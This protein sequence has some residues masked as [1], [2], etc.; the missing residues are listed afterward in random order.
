[1]SKRFLT[2]LALV[3]MLIAAMAGSAFAAPTKW[4][5]TTDN[6][7]NKAANWDSGLPSA[8]NDAVFDKSADVKVTATIEVEKIT[9]NASL[10][11]VTITPNNGVELKV[12]DAAGITANSNLTIAGAGLVL[13]AGV[14]PV[15]LTV[16]AGAV[17]NF[18]GP[19]NAA[20]S[21][22]QK[23]G[24]GA[25]V[26]SGNTAPTTPVAL[27]VAAGN[28]FLAKGGLVGAI[29]IDANG[30]DVALA[31]S[32]DATMSTAGDLT[33][34]DA[35]S[36]VITIAEGAK[37]TL[38]DSLVFADAL[39]GGATE[40][41]IDGTLEA[42]KGS[43]P[44]DFTE[45]VLEINGALDLK[46]A[47]VV[48][49][50][51]GDGAISTVFDLTFTEDVTV[52]A[53]ISGRGN[54][55]IDNNA[56]VEFVAT[57]TY[58]GQ[59]TVAGGTTLK[60]HGKENLGTGA[61]T[62][63]GTFL[64]LEGDAVLPNTVILMAGNK[65]EVSAD[66]TLAITNVL[67]SNETMDKEGEGK[68]IL[69]G[70]AVS[71]PSTGVRD[72]IKVT[73]GTVVISSDK[74]AGAGDLNV[75]TGNTL[76]IAPGLT[77]TNKIDI[78][79]N[80]N[81]GVQISDGQAAFKLDGSTI[82][83]AGDVNIV[84]VTEGSVTKDQQFLVIDAAT[85]GTIDYTA[86]T[87]LKPVDAAGSALPFTPSKTT[88]ASGEK[89]YFTA[90]KNMDFPVIGEADK[91]E[92]EVSSDVTINIAVESMSE[93]RSPDFKAANPA[94]SLDIKVSGKQL[95]LT[96]KAPAVSGDF[97]F[98]VM[99]IASGDAETDGFASERKEFTM[100][101]TEESVTPPVSED[102][103]IDGTPVA[104]KENGTYSISA[105]LYRNGMLAANEAVTG[106]LDG[107]AAARRGANYTSDQ[108]TDAAGK[109]T[110]S[111]TGIE[112]DTYSFYVTD[113]SGA[114]LFGPMPVT[115][116]EAGVVPPVSSD[117]W[118]SGSSGCDAGFGLFALLAGVGAAVVLRKKD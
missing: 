15:V 86:L 11:G 95:V 52:S 102:S 90:T 96:G 29:N 50:I 26:F 32:G 42:A 16:A 49:V 78:A 118:G 59:T 94:L 3:A 53:D 103:K 46:D 27:E 33:I 20:A 48:G 21:T 99:V 8:T 111:F 23:A 84:T 18:A 66:A 10:A 108:T 88:D 98:D 87:N 82:D 69:S 60:I 37:L 115:D 7:W 112:E 25:L 38:A 1:M 117:D 74:A 63:E 45:E 55:L 5:G 116:F 91:L 51:S 81:L 113:A 77:L 43:T 39:T 89:L 9:I 107:T 62:V 35:D 56:E 47:T 79:A 30:E 14:N 114:R 13:D 2:I 92:F 40:F 64:V 24:D 67:F 19:V 105:I 68:L 85:P 70:T 28:V 100:T 101:V 109:A 4:V 17:L 22:M 75:L 76:E 80:G 110:F 54:V 34:T 57:N 58:E 97:T 73:K 31:V 104:D 6:D 72:A 36:V 93:L 44:Y 83:F 61:L 12:K 71:A 106:H 41:I 65:F